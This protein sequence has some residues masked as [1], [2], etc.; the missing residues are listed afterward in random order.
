MKK[1]KKRPPRFSFRIYSGKRLSKFPPVKAGDEVE[2][3][4]CGKDHKLK[5]AVAVQT[6][7]RDSLFL[8]YYCK[9]EWRIGAVF[10]KLLINRKAD[11]QLE[12]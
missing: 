4:D 3:Y 7:K 11:N 2:C 10:G 12:E 8:V 6:K 5:S 1:Q 9:R